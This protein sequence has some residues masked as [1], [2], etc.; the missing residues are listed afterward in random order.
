MEY[1]VSFPCFLSSRAHTDGKFIHL[2]PQ[3]FSGE[4]VAELVD[5]H[6]EAEKQDGEQDI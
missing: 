3:Q 5:G 6:Q 1:R 4:K 2:D